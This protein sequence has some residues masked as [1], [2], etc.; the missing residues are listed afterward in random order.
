MFL[1]NNPNY[2]MRHRQNPSEVRHTRSILI[3]DY[4]VSTCRIFKQIF[5]K[6]GYTVDLAKDGEEAKTKMKNNAYDAALI[7]FILPDMDGLD[8]V[9]Y[10]HK[11]MPNA[12]KIVT[13]GYPN[14]R[15]SIKV[16][17]AGADAYFS[18]PINPEELVRVVEEK[19]ARQE[20]ANAS[21]ATPKSSGVGASSGSYRGRIGMLSGAC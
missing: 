20:K 5:Q 7:N 8:L 21:S 9:L 14:L 19:L 6:R 10:T 12:A 16:I 1:G 18:K 15:D 11:T 4:D 3:V 2:A 17:E 13:T